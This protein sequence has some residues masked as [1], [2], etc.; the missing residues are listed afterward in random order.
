M[1]SQHAQVASVEG[2][3]V[4]VAIALAPI[5]KQFQ[6]GP[7][8][9]ILTEALI[10][11]LGGNWRVHIL[12]GSADGRGGGPNGEPGR[13]PVESPE[14]F[15]PGDG[16]EPESDPEPGASLDKAARPRGPDPVDLLKSQLGATVIE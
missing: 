3:R 12:T 9:E 11:V 10:E 6:N 7:G 1:L 15:A 14:G 2:D 5:A 4:A 13:E 8:I 16:P